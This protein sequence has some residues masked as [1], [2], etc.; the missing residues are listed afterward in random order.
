MGEEGEQVGCCRVEGETRGLDLEKREPGDPEA[1]CFHGWSDQ[2]VPK[3]CHL[4][5]ETSIKA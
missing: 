2:W 5:L 1:P 3:E 4:E